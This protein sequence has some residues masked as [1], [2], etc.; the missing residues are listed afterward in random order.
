MKKNSIITKDNCYYRILAIKDKEI[1]AIDCVKSTMPKWHM[2]SHFDSY[3]EVSESDLLKY[4]NIELI[5]IEELPSD[6]KRIAYERYTL[7]AAV[8]PFIYDSSVQL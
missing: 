1:L 8:L 5:N 7:I 6:C 4:L 3:Q 2:I